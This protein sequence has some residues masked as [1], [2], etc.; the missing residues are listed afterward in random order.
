MLEYD[1]LTY[2]IRGC[3]YEVFKCLGAGFVE[4]VYERALVHELGLRGFEVRAQCPIE[5]R[6]KGFVVGDFYADVLVEDKVI[7]ELKAQ[8]QISKENEAQLLN[9]LK[10]TE[11][12]VGMLVNFT[13]PKATI[14]RFVL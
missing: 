13:Y 5:V 7:L 3:V 8:R 4:K 11:L 10:A 12:K 1:E 9:Y 6:Y 2:D 14:K